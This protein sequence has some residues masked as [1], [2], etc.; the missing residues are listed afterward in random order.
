M[1]TKPSKVCSD[2]EW[3]DE[4]DADERMK[5]KASSRRDSKV[6]KR[7]RKANKKFSTEEDTAATTDDKSGGKKR[8]KKQDGSKKKRSR[9][10]G[11]SSIKRVREQ[12]RIEQTK[13]AKKAEDEEARKKARKSELELDYH[14]GNIIAAAED[15][16]EDAAAPE[17]FFWEVEAVVGRRVHRGR[18]EYLIRWKGCSEDD[19]TWEPTSN[20]CD[21]ASEFAADVCL[22]VL[23]FAY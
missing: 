1:S 17:D 7:N 13:A 6:G 14:P 2:L 15:K 16:E 18:I 9:S 4:V 5:R 21:T 19:N 22:F 12:R 10:K 3:K 8:S 11:A 20:L 23:L